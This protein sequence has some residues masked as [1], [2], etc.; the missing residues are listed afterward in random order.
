MPRVVPSQVVE[1][2]SKLFP[3]VGTEQEGRP[4][5]LP[6][7]QSAACLALLDLI[8]EIP[9]ELLV[10]DSKQY[11][12]LI[13]SVA[14]IRDTIETWR[15]WDSASGSYF[16]LTEVRGLRKLNPVGLIR[17]A[18]A[19]CPDE[20]PARGTSQLSFISDPE[21]RERLRLDIGAV[22]RAFANLEW[23]A[24]TVLAGS[25]IEA[26]LLWV[27]EEHFA[28][29]L[30]DSV[31]RL[32]AARVCRKPNSDPK[33]WDLHLYI[34]VATDLGVVEQD[35]A[36]LV[37]LAKDYRNFIHPGKA[38]RLQQECNRSTAMTAIAALDRVTD[39]LARRLGP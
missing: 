20:F 11:M 13:A 30:A 14:A 24:A 3:Q 8:D 29:K 32:V 23:K 12:E 36:K 33:Y 21:L 4:F 17:E 7:D 26:L 9:S 19:R 28:G 35:T 39:D 18:L 2:I 1:L 10:M 31:D 5:S 37:R 25:V 27:L 6:P 16:V 15:N 38:Q 22:E 34:E